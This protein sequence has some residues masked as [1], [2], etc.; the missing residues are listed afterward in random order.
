MMNSAFKMM[1]CDT[2][3]ESV[4]KIASAMF[5]LKDTNDIQSADPKA[6]A[7]LHTQ[8][9]VLPPA[10][11][12]TILEALPLDQQ[13]MAAAALEMGAGMEEAEVVELVAGFQV[14]YWVL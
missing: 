6:I 9:K 12:A 4:I 10:I 1:S 11:T 14:T 2:I 7:A 13:G 8:L 5:S 3:Q